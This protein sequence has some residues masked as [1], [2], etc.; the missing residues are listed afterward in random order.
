[1]IPRYVPPLNEESCDANR[2][3]RV[4]FAQ[5]IFSSQDF[6]TALFKRQVFS[7]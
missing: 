4:M 7:P 5:N 1:M 3:F 2:S 6:T